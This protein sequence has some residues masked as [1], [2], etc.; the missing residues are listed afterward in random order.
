MQIY[1]TGHKQNRF[2][3]KIGHNPDIIRNFKQIRGFYW[4]GYRQIWSFPDT[5]DNLNTVLESVYCNWRDNLIDSIVS[6]FQDDL[7]LLKYSR[8]TMSNYTSCVREYLNLHLE[9]NAP[10]K[11]KVR[12][13][14]LNKINNGASTS[15]ISLYY[16][17]LKL[18]GTK[19]LGEDIVEN[20]EMPSKDKK[21]PHVLSH[22]DVETL[23][24]N[25]CNHKHRVILMLIY[26][27][28]LRVSEASTIKLRDIDFNRNTIHIKNAKGRK[29]RITILSSR[30]KPHLFNYIKKYKPKEWL[31]EGEEPGSHI[32][33]RSIQRIFKSA[34]IKS[35]III[36]ASIH[37]LRHSFATHLLENGTDI[38]YIQELLGHSSTKT[39]MIYT[40]VTGNAIRKIRSPFDF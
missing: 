29:D 11:F 19:L 26:S 23:F 16:S 35:N 15:S 22:E 14:L 31:F 17:A 20:I 9:D 36:D 27:A 40:K 10:E 24:N 4:D 12:S 32:S 8:S 39:T 38:R 6:Q 33:I 13:Y 5:R 7:K 28:G 3:V 30:F 25:T 21:L 18:Y 37:S 34:L 2:S 1:I